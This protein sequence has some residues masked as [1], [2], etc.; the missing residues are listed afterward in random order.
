MYSLPIG[1]LCA[2]VS[3]TRIWTASSLENVYPDSMP[4]PGAEP[5]A[6][7]YAAKGEYE[8]F[9]I[10]VR[11]SRRA[12]DNLDAASEAL[13]K[14]IGPPEIRRVDYLSVTSRSS[15]AYGEQTARPDPLSAFEPFALEQDTTGALWVTYYVPPECPG[16]LYEGRVAVHLGGRAK[17]YIGVTLEVFD[18]EIPA[19]PSVTAAMHLAPGAIRSFCGISGDALEEWKHLYN[20]LNPWRIAYNSALPYPDSPEG[21]EL[22]LQHLLYVA[23]AARMSAV[24]LGMGETL[25]NRTTGAESAATLQAIAETVA[26]Q[27]WARRV[28]AEPMPPLPRSHWPELEAR[29]AAFAENA[30]TIPRLLECV[31]H[32]EIQELARIWVIPLRFFDPIAIQRLRNGMALWA[33]LPYPLETV[34]ASSSARIPTQDMPYASTAMDACDASLYTAWTSANIP[35]K[36]AP[37]WLE[38]RLREPTATKTVR[39]G[40]R[41]GH[42]AVDPL[43]EVSPDGSLWVPARVTW[44]HHGSSRRFEQSWSEGAFDRERRFIGIRISFTQ[45]ANNLPVSVTEVELGRAPDPTSIE[46]LSAGAQVW[47]EQTT[48]PFPSFHVDA[49]PVEARLAP[50]LCWGHELDG[51]FGQPLNQ[52]PKGWGQPKTETPRTWPAAGTGE[53]FL[54]YPGKQTVTPSIR[55]HRLRDG[56]EDFEY[57][58]AAM[59]I[60]VDTAL[61]GP[62]T[63]MLCRWEDYTDSL[64]PSRLDDVR[65]ML[66]ELRIAIGRAATKAGT[67]K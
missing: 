36:T 20:A 62:E 12:I 21:K 18:F 16:G 57:I 27:A 23:D 29:Y 37:E 56:L 32:P 38:L 50:W 8:S 43:I 34:K 1:L 54:V 9:Q 30:P 28:Y 19:T 49:H 14:T 55:L 13:S 4:P 24:C 11:S 17:R 40:W 58:R 60:G 63:M 2:M 48:A 66:Q 61:L 33:E 64:S 25:A 46:Y 39:I 15:R 7:L 44:K 41:A 35:T 5:H 51:F 45:T 65:S 52:W 10:C 42:E 47:F 67:N 6:R 59:N 26:G 31:P 22:Y 3:A 53:Q